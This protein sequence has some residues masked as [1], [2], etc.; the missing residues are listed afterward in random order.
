MPIPTQVFLK[1]NNIANSEFKTIDDIQESDMS[2]PM[3]VEVNGDHIN[4]VI[5]SLCQNVN[6]I[7]I[8]INDQN[9]L[10]VKFEEDVSCKR[11]PG[12]KYKAMMAAGNYILH[13]NNINSYDYNFLFRLDFKYYH[14]RIKAILDTGML[15][16]HIPAVEGLDS[17]R[18]PVTKLSTLDPQLQ[19]K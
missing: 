19:P 2:F 1:D 3:D 13:H 17:N 9:Y 6:E 4:I 15:V 8:T 16:I 7:F 10:S 18:I 12:C 5:A 11:C 14:D